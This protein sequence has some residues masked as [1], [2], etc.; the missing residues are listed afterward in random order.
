MSLT[1]EQLQTIF[2]S[3]ERIDVLSDYLYFHNK[4][5][6]DQIKAEAKSIMK[7][8]ESVIGQQR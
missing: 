8:I 7:A 5:R 1:R 3:A 4:L 2:L 6:A